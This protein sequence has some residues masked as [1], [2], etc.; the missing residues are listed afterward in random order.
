MLNKVYNNIVHY[1]ISLS[2]ITT[3]MKYSLIFIALAIALSITSCMK[4][5]AIDTDKNLI[6]SFSQD[7]ILFDTVFTTVGSATQ[8]LKIYN[9]SDKK[10][11]ISSIRMGKGSDSP[12]RFNVDGISSI[13]VTD[14][15]LQGKDSAF[16][17]VKVTIDPNEANS[18]LVQQDSLVFVTNNNTQDVKLVAWGQ[19]AYFYN[20][21]I[22]G[23]DYVFESDKPHVI[24]NYLVV[25]SLYTL[26]V[27][28]GARIHLHPGAFILVYNTASLKVKGTADQPVI[29]EGDRLEDYYKT[30]PGQ[31]GRIWLYAGSVNNEIDY[32]I[33]RNGET[34]I[35][36]DTVGNS[37]NPTLRINNS[38]IY[39]MTDIGLLAQGT[40]VEAR[41]CVFA[42]CGSYTV[43]LT[44]GGSYDFRH[45][46]IGNYWRRFQRYSG[47]ILNNYYIDINKE[48]QSRPLENAYFGNCVIYG[49]N[50]D[51]LTLDQSPSSSTYNYMFDNCLVKTTLPVSDPA[52]F[53]NTTR[54]QE[55]WFKDPLLA[56]FEPDST[57][58]S[59]I[60]KGSLEVINS[61]NFDLTKDLKQRSRISDT[62]PDLGAYEFEER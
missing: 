6:L 30:L 34:G 17:F 21:A 51:E 61:S 13:E 14:L 41:N 33:I 10:I 50:T 53:T 20:R 18:P 9:P 46:T 52:H 25:D 28:A 8:V 44:L 35:Q 23:S 26:E 3:M 5:D 29:I 54:N 36:V 24:Y 1:S 2:V 40:S 4:D 55:P 62:A 47:L 39:N 15:E 45:C 27:L 59:V 22:I 11:N 49:D 16:V 43:A 38:L 19:D 42:N 56:E 37:T 58:S 60:N 32:A 57:L 31:W 7:T 48:L 12:Y